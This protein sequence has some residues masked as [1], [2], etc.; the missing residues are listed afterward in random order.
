MA[1]IDLYK[2]LRNEDRYPGGI[3]PWSYLAMPALLTV[4]DDPDKWETLWPASDQP[5]DGQN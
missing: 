1:S 3:V 5:F 2:E 4:D